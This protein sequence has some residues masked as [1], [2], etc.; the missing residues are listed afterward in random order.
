MKKTFSERLREALEIRHMT[1]AELSR[2]SGVSKAQISE[3][4]KGNYEAKQEALYKLALALNVSEAWI[5]GYDVD[6]KR[7]YPTGSLKTD[8]EILI[9]KVKQMS[10]EEV[11]A[12]LLILGSQQK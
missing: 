8:K 3:Y 12:V 4:I 10:D 1:A 2:R 6:M 7:D 9:D 11:R 5:M